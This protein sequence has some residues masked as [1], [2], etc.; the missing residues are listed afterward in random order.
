MKT[1]FFKRLGAYLFDFIVVTFIVSIITMGFKSNSDVM[2]RMN[3]L[4]TGVTNEEISMEEYSN[5]MFELNYEYQ[6]SVIPSTAVSVVI[7]IGYFIIFA[8][9]NNG[10]TLGKKVFKIKVVDKDGNKPSIWNM[11]G[12]SI[13]LYGIFT[14][15]INI[16]CV[17][18]LNVKLF[19]YTSTIIN[20]IYYMFVIMCFFMVMYRKDGRGMHDIIGKT[21]IKEKVK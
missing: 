13:P 8:Y 10:Q 20:Y 5:Q 12:R 19:N 16:I 6:K 21:F 7:S 18:I 11:L 3:E 1:L 15:T 4:I 14:G 9:L 2:N 17:Y